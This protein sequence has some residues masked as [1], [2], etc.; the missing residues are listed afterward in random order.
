MKLQ[1]NIL[2]NISRIS[3]YTIWLITEQQK[4]ANRKLTQLQGI[5]TGKKEGNIRS[6][7]TAIVMN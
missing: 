6:W 4:V 1:N 7:K 5:K 3:F 2:A